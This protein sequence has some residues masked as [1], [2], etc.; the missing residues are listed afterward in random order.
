MKSVLR[1]SRI[2]TAESGSSMVEATLCLLGFIFLALG[3]ME[4]AMAINAYDSVAFLA[5]EGSRYAALHG[6]HSADP[7]SGDEVRDY[8]RDRSVPLSRSSVM[9]TTSWSP[10]NHPGSQVAVQVTYRISPMINLMLKEPINVSST[11]KMTISY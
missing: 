10:D 1:K 2:R 11:S 6:A 4:F 3:V 8:V 9:V 7:A 5:R